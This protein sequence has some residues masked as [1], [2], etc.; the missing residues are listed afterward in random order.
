MPP[1]RVA[2]AAP[3]RPVARVTFS[4]DRL[5]QIGE[6]KAILTDGFNRREPHVGG[7]PANSVFHTH[8][9][10]HSSVH[11]HWA[12]LSMARTTKD[13][14]L[15]NLAMARLSPTALRRERELLRANPTFELPYGQAWLLLTMNEIAKHPGGNTTD[16]RAL[17]SET[18]VRVLDWLER[19]PFPE[20]P[21]D[22][23]NAAHDSWLFAYSLLKQSE[24]GPAARARMVA[25][26]AKIDRARPAIAR[27]RSLETD[28]LDLGAVLGVIERTPPRRPGVGAYPAGKAGGLPREPIDFANVHSAGTAAMR[29]WPYAMDASAGR[30]NAAK[31]VDQRLAEMMKRP[32]LYKTGFE[33]ASHWVPQFIWMAMLQQAG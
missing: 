5:K 2:G 17:R 33:T 23:L 13:P 1:V 16:V 3:S 14:A 22:Q 30:P 9:D 18:E 25:L 11:A 20:G 19:S 15:E 24:P 7:A 12:A 21:R 27:H 28:F 6:L 32:E 26:E 31:Q 4:A 8:Y 29:L 10:W